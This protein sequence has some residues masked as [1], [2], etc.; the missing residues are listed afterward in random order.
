[1]AVTYMSG[2]GKFRLSRGNK[3]TLFVLARDEPPQQ[4]LLD[5]IAAGAS[6]DAVEALAKAAAADGP[7]VAAP[8][9]SPAAAGAWRL[10]WTKQGATANPLQRRLAGSVRNW[11][12]ISDDGS[13]LE[14]RVEI[15]PGLL[16]VRALAEC[17]P[18]S[19]TRTGVAINEVR[20]ELGP[21]VVPLPVARDARGF[22]DWLYLDEGMR[23]TRGSKGSLFVHV[24]DPT[25]KE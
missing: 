17:A 14:N 18:D 22:V 2:D 5:A 21:L 15:I 13:R 8:A 19:P 1:M 25:V 20:I 23:V 7:G 4:Q 24:R 6:E 16:R 11:Q 3:G 10:V 9:R 12:I